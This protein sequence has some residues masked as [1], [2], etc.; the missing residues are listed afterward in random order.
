[1]DEDKDEG[2][3]DKDVSLDE[4]RQYSVAL[5]QHLQDQLQTRQLVT[6]QRHRRTKRRRVTRQ[7]TV[8]DAE[9]GLDITKMLR[10]D[11]PYVPPTDP[12]KLRD[13]LQKLL[14][15]A[16][17]YKKKGYF[18]LKP[19]GPPVPPPTPSE[20]PEVLRFAPEKLQEIESF[21]V[22]ASLPS[23]DA[24]VDLLP[25]LSLVSAAQQSQGGG[26]V[27][28]PPVDTLS[29]S[30]GTRTLPQHWCRY[31]E[32][33]TQSY[34]TPFTP[35]P[36]PPT[37]PVRPDIPELDLPHSTPAPTTRPRPRIPGMVPVTTPSPPTT[38]TL[39]TPEVDYSDYFDNYDYDVSSGVDTGLAGTRT[40]GLAGRQDD[41]AFIIV[42]DDDGGDVEGSTDGRS[43][44]TGKKVQQ[45]VILVDPSG[46]DAGLAGRRWRGSQVL[47]VKPN[48][49]GREGTAGVSK[50]RSAIILVEEEPEGAVQDTG[51]RGIGTQSA[52]IILVDEGDEEGKDQNLL[53]VE[54]ITEPRDAR[55]SAVILVDEGSG[56][57]LSPSGV[58]TTDSTLILVNGDAGS[59][60]QDRTQVLQDQVG[61][62][63][64]RHG[65]VLPTEA[66]DE[67]VSEGEVKGDSGR[68]KEEGRR[69]IILVNAAGED[70]TNK[71]E[72]KSAIILVNSEEKETKEDEKKEEKTTDAQ[73]IILINSEEN[74]DEDGS[75]GRSAIILVNAE[76]EDER[77][78]EGETGKEV[79]EINEN[80]GAI[81]LVESED[82]TLR[83]GGRGE[84]LEDALGS[85][86]ILVQEDDDSFTQ[87]TTTTLDHTT[88]TKPTQLLR[89]GHRSHVVNALLRPTG[90][91][92]KALAELRASGT[93]SEET[94]RTAPEAAWRGRRVTARTRRL[95]PLRRRW[96]AR[97]RSLGGLGDLED[98]PGSLRETTTG[99][100][101]GEQEDIEPLGEDRYLSD[102]DAD[103]LELLTG[104]RERQREAEASSRHHSVGREE[105]LIG[106][107]EFIRGGGEAPSGLRETG[108]RVSP[109]F[110]SG[111]RKRR[112]RKRL[113]GST[114]LLPDGR[115]QEEF[116]PTGGYGGFGISGTPP[117]L[118]PLSPLP[119][120]SPSIPD[121]IR[122]I[123]QAVQARAAAWTSLGLQRTRPA[124][125]RPDRQ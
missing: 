47:L 105:Y 123:S 70:G 81:I 40:R 94:L 7:T 97:S 24:S 108:R 113:R 17:D 104:L 61:P 86:I 2:K 16:N 21:G 52:A 80:K 106:G 3:D 112:R 59:F 48:K 8:A 99:G 77:K 23:E 96:T 119:P 26:Y 95:R 50:P 66:E 28:P 49:D 44:S 10:H 85:V 64:R 46:G 91:T 92:L 58:R 63:G 124:F 20:A 42:V 57:M 13:A 116:N 83:V 41:R 90:S 37:L 55:H 75:D 100:R 15:L 125:R 67:G 12:K 30:T 56:S 115:T 78:Q 33:H 27:P 87:D 101:G 5:Y 102:S 22:D 9:G 109:E 14:Q 6:P 39:A 31:P 84:A 4:V 18:Y 118:P 114:E 45:A 1:M 103:L 36:R 71:I 89:E 117:F 79:K 74:E 60:T 19:N 73:T 25:L 122:E 88:T 93:I 76:K 65:T 82:G 54:G 68:R 43:T 62:R 32:A 121:K 38:L 34:S 110:S 69:A 107:R 11:M 111:T 98:S 51:V 72:A 53:L 35:R 29:G 120:S